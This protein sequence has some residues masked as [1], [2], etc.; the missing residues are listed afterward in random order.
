MD[1]IIL[2]ALVVGITQIIKMTLALK[3]RYIPV[4]TLVVSLV[5]F[6]LGAWLADTVTFGWDLVQNALV[7]ALV[8][9][10]LWSG[11]KSTFEK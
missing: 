10:G 1:A 9:C 7:T 11:G 6:S 2:G 3:S 8:S 4:T 5:I